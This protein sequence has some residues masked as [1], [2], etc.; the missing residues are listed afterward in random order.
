MVPLGGLTPYHS[1]QP[2][3]QPP[4]HP[5]WPPF[6]G[7]CGDPKRIVLL[8]KGQK[9][10]LPEGDPI[11]AM[12]GM[13]YASKQGI[14]IKWGA[15]TTGRSPQGR[16]HPTATSRQPSRL[17]AHG[18]GQ[19]PPSGTST[20]RFIASMGRCRS[21]SSPRGKRPLPHRRKPR[22]GGRRHDARVRRVRGAA[23]WPHAH[24]PTLH[25]WSLFNQNIIPQD[26]YPQEA[27]LTNQ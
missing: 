22:A 19:V 1:N 17:I 8:P 13:A 11:P 23:R 25:F 21:P 18:L 26:I 14:V 27:T 3:P 2:Q 7:S 5:C 4:P 24:K 15:A 9:P 16:F 12:L 10:Q 6:S 20:R